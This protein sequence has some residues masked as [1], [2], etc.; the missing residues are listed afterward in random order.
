MAKLE[1]TYVY[2]L[3]KFNH[4]LGRVMPVILTKSI[5]HFRK[6]QKMDTLLI[7]L[8]HSIFFVRLFL[9]RMIPTPK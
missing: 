1:L 8:F 2:L 7:Q 9:L 5:I 3:P 6:E 4:T